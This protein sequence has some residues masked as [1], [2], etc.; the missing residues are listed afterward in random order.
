MA[1]GNRLED[2]EG[3]ESDTVAHLLPHLCGNNINATM[4]IK[5]LIPYS[6]MWIK[7]AF[8]TNKACE[9]GPLCQCRR[10]SRKSLVQSPGHASIENLFLKDYYAELVKIGIVT[11]SIVNN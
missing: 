1:V 4:E 6:L 9:P 2:A 8:F 10:L 3:R 11:V 7:K 5:V